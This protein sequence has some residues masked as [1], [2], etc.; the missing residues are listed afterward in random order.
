LN[1]THQL[2]LCTYDADDVNILDETI[3]II[4]ENTEALFQAARRLT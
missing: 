4:K 1:G 3:Y 2:F